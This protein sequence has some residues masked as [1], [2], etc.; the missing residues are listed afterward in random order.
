MARLPVWLVDWVLGDWW[1]LGAGW[2]RGCA[3]IWLAGSLA[4]LIA[5]GDVKES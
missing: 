1:K 3:P 5:E 4:R 2:V